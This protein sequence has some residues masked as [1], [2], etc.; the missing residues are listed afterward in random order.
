[1]NMVDINIGNIVTIGLISIVVVAGAKAI[2]TKMGWG[3][4][5]L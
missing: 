2:S 5:W 1:M 4:G 3:A